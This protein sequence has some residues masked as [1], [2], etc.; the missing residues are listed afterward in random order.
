MTLTTA[1]GSIINPGFAYSA[2]VSEFSGTTKSVAMSGRFFPA[3][4][5]RLP[6]KAVRLE[7]EPPY[8]LGFPF[9]HNERQFLDYR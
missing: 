9:V 6:A 1:V 7:R 8:S 5:L 2:Q 4:L 3:A